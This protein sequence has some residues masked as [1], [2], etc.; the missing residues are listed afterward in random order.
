MRKL[1]SCRNDIYH[2]IFYHDM[3]DVV[4]EYFSHPTHV[5]HGNFFSKKIKINVFYFFFRKAALMSHNFS[6]KRIGN[7]RDMRGQTLFGLEVLSYIQYSQ[8]FNGVT[9]TITDFVRLISVDFFN[10]FLK[11]LTF[12]CRQF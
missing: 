11:F 2:E 4:S 12:S 6:F 7:Y 1:L 10:E 9:V 8:R 3:F 5:C